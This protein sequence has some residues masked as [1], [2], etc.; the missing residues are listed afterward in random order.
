MLGNQCI[1]CGDRDVGGLAPALG[2]PTGRAVRGFNKRRRDRRYRW[3]IDIDQHARPAR[4]APHRQRL[5]RD[6]FAAAIE[7]PE[8]P[9]HRPLRLDRDDTRAQPA[10]RGDAITNMR[11][12]VEYQIARPDEVAI[13]SVHRRSPPPVSVIDT[14]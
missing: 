8:S 3:V 10:E 9:H 2:F 1:Q 14:K 4:L 5:D 7:Q 6:R 11:A 12:N 13:K